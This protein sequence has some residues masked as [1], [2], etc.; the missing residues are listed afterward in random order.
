MGY[1]DFLA[2]CITHPQ[3]RSSIVLPGCVHLSVCHSHSL[4]LIRSPTP[5]HVALPAV[6]L[7]PSTLLSLR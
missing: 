4:I 5:L 1:D 3:V 2:E 7:R 6:P